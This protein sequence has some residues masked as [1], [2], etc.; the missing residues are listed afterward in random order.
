MCVACR[1]R[2]VPRK[3]AGPSGRELHNSCG[4]TDVWSCARGGRRTM[5]AISRLRP[6]SLL[7]LAVLLLGSAMLV[8]ALARAQSTPRL[9]VQEI[10]ATGDPAPGFSPPAVIESIGDVPRI[11]AAGDVSAIAVVRDPAAGALQ[12]LYRT[13]GGPVELVFRSGDPA[14]GLA[15][16]FLLFPGA[17]QTP[18]IGSGRLTFAAEVE[19]AAAPGRTGIWSDRAG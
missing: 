1:R 5:P 10:L 9:T 8:A 14:P 7:I 6:R 15:G 11:D 2:S 19:Q 12:V 13:L 4:S 3:A 16:D 18:R 17:P